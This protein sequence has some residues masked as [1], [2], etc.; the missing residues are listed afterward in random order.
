MIAVALSSFRPSSTAFF[1]KWQYLYIYT[2]INGRNHPTE[3]MAEIEKDELREDVTSLP[4]YIRDTTDFL[5]KIKNIPQPLS[6]GTLIF[7]LDVKALYIP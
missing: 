2:Y 7:C 4:S 3:K 6:E 1:F 5:N